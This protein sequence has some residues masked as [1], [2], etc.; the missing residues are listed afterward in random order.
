MIINYDDFIFG[1]D[2]APFG[3]L[4]VVLW[5]SCKLVVTGYVVD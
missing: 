4:P 3:G 1:A 5:Q 2:L